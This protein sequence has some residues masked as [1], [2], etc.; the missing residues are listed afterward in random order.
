MKY[1]FARSEGNPVTSFTAL[2][3]PVNV[4]RRVYT[5]LG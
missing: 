4:A 2:I 1:A 5:V 3:I